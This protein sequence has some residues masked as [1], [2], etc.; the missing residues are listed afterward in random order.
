MP[1]TSYHN[2]QENSY[3]ADD[4]EDHEIE[5]ITNIKQE[6]DSVETGVYVE[7]E[8][9]IEP[10][11]K[12]SRPNRIQWVQKKEFSSSEE[13]I[14]HVK[15][16][17]IWSVKHTKPMSKS[18][19]KRQYFRCNLVPKAQPRQCSCVMALVTKSDGSTVMLQSV[20]AHDH[21]KIK[22]ELKTE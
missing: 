7:S 5:Q 19:E 11:K 6:F 15:T 16:Q 22:G 21:F 17:K 20:Q 12:K 4:T 18:G 2:Y 14:E 8:T 9:P 1:E 13:A 3:A 10:K